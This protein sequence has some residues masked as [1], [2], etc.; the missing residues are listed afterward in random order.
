MEAHQLRVIDEYA[1]LVAK[2]GNFLQ[3]AIFKPDD[4]KGLLQKQHVLLERIRRF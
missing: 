1:E 2:R 3:G 4:D